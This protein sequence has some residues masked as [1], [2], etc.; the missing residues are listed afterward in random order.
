M[1]GTEWRKDCRR[2]P[3]QQ[4]YPNHALCSQHLPSLS[5]R[6][7]SCCIDITLCR[8]GTYF[9]SILQMWVSLAFPEPQGSI[10][11]WESITMARTAPMSGASSCSTEMATSMHIPLG[12][13]VLHVL[14]E[15]MQDGITLPLKLLGTWVRTRTEVCFSAYPCCLQCQWTVLGVCGGVSCSPAG[16]LTVMWNGYPPLWLQVEKFCFSTGV[17]CNH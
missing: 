8:W 11:Y 17:F 7:L 1:V 14:Q 16:S 4:S 5:L 12:R 10:K 9:R 3:K 6:V 2:T 15:W 13:S